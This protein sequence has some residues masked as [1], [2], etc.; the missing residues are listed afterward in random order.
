M[1]RSS[2]LLTTLM[3]LSLLPAIGN[4]QQTNP[5]QGNNTGHSAERTRTDSKDKIQRNQPPSDSATK[6]MRQNAQ[7]AGSDHAFVNKA[8]EGGMMEVHHAEMALRQ[9]S[10][11]DVKRYAQRLIDDH[12][13]ANQELMSLAANKGITPSGAMHGQMAGMPPDANP[14]RD[15]TP[16]SATGATNPNPETS[17][18]MRKTDPGLKKSDQNK[19]HNSGMD[20]NHAKMMERMS[21]L[22]GADFDR[23]Y[24]KMEVKEHQKTIALFEKQSRSGRDAELKAFAAKTLP[25]LREHYQ[26]ARD[27]ASKMAGSNGTNASKRTQARTRP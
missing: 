9:S 4:A 17:G 1:L 6:S 7:V 21:K 25:T 2:T 15:I 16:S 27:L 8:A 13:K 26:L 19:Y 20:N 5:Q 12:T 14:S 23:E 10:N 18:D 22:S 24:I 11:E 3:M